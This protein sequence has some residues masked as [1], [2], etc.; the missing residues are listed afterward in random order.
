ML[1]PGVTILSGNAATAVL[2]LLRNLA[3]AALIPVADYG[4]AA[5][6]AIV[7]AVIEMATDLGLHQ[8]IVQSDKGEDARFQKGLQGFQA[9]RGLIA[10]GL[11]LA[12]AGPLAVFLGIPEVAW[13]YQLLALVPVLNGLQHFD[14][15]RLNRN[16]VFGP[17]ILTRMMPALVSL[18]L[19]WPLAAWLGDY[20]VMLWAI[21]AQAAV[22][23]VLSHVTAKRPYGL[24]FDL[25][26]MRESL[27]F[28][29]PLLVNGALLFVVFQGDKI[30]VGRGMGMEALALL[31]MGFTLTLTP[32]MVLAR[33]TQN[34]FLPQLSQRQDDPDLPQVVTQVA[35]L[36]GLMLILGTL[37]V[38]APL[39][40]VVL[41]EKYAALVPLLLPLAV[42]HALRVAK[43]APATIALSRG[44]TS[45]A[46]WGN[47]P[48]LL[49]LVGVIYAVAQGAGLDMVI[50]IAC[51]GEVAGVMLAFWLLKTRAGLSIAPWPLGAWA[52]CLAVLILIPERFAL[53]AAVG[54]ILAT[55]VLMRELQA[56]LRRRVPA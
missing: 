30:V 19:V 51:V 37:A 26:V 44:L 23:L 33:S 24:V 17:L 6:F 4:V 31:A 49:S 35:L 8:Q 45:N 32:T 9:L 18:L 34:F 1:R 43:S 54:L 10:G 7:M 16:M 53:M 28:G 39:V 3:V 40:T 5:T 48:R 25:G 22:M 38:T 15:H 55:L 36:N 21:L 42:L 14:I 29:W 52:L 56:Y 41:G 2:L 46:L 13:A 20:R 27:A 47:A 12:V 50:W 11:L